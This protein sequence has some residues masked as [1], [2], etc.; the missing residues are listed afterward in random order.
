MSKAK[1]I[2]MLQS[3]S[4]FP[5]WLTGK[6]KEIAQELLK[7]NFCY[8]GL[9]DNFCKAN[10]EWKCEGW[11]LGTAPGYICIDAVYDGLLFSRCL[12]TELEGWSDSEE[13]YFDSVLKQVKR[14]IR[15]TGK[16]YKTSVNYFQLSIFN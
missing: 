9:E 5:C 1:I 4:S 12:E 8:C 6:H 13:E 15:T 3:S 11:G 16:K 14:V 7:I 2:Y 10:I